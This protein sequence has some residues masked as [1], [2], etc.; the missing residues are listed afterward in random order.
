MIAYIGHDYFL[1]GKTIV[2]CVDVDLLNGFARVGVPDANGM[3]WM[4]S[5]VSFERLSEKK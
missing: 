3:I 1:D 4:P 5:W 2:H